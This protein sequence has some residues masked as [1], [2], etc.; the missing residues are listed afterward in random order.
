MGLLYLLAYRIWGVLVLCFPNCSSQNF[1]RVC[2]SA[3]GA[4]NRGIRFIMI[5]IKYSVAQR[6]VG[7]LI[8]GHTL[9]N[10]KRNVVMF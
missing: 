9:L 7:L 2:V 1:M 8:G 6:F 10:Y 3:R 5:F 4:F